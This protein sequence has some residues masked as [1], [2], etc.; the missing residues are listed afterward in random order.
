MGMLTVI[1]MSCQVLRVECWDAKIDNVDGKWV[2]SNSCTAVFRQK[3]LCPWTNWSSIVKWC[4]WDGYFR[5]SSV[6]NVILVHSTLYVVYTYLDKFKELYR[7]NW[8]TLTQIVVKADAHTKYK[9]Y[10]LHLNNLFIR[11]PLKQ[12]MMSFKLKITYLRKHFPYKAT[13]QHFLASQ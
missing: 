4:P 10:F 8:C 12:S 9:Y 2:K 5:D 13:V 3:N 6:K 7:I 11:N 1:S